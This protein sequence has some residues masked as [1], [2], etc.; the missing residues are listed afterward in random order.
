TFQFTVTNTGTQTG[1][2][3]SI[4]I[5]SSSFQLGALPPLP[6]QLAPNNSVTFPVTFTAPASGQS[7][8]TLLVNSQSFTLVGTA[9]SLPAL[10]TYHFT[11]A[12]SALPFQQPSIGLS[13]DAPY[14]LPITGSLTMNLWTSN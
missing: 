11:G 4:A 10:P 8:A 2:I 13:L 1:T 12:T 9:A 7:T 6:L 5:P 3:F 14:P